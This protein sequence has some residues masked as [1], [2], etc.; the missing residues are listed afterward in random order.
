[1]YWWLHFIGIR[2]VLDLSNLSWGSN[3]ASFGSEGNEC[4]QWGMD[5]VLTV[6]EASEKELSLWTPEN[7]LVFDLKWFILV[8]SEVINLKFFIVTKIS[9][10]AH[11][12]D[13]IVA[14]S[15]LEGFL[16]SLV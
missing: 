7:L 16:N 10:G 11:A 15:S 2:P 14:A 3:R 1:M 6:E 8:Y 5:T 12:I 4:G 9:N 13:C